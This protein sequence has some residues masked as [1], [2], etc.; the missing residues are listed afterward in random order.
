MGRFPAGF[1]GQS[2]AQMIRRYWSAVGFDVAVE[3]IWSSGADERPY[4]SIRSNL[5]AG[6]PR[7]NKT[8]GG[9]GDG[10]R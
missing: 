6:L 5:V 7:T 10:P 2:A 8:N 4:Y 9:G 3:I 1:P